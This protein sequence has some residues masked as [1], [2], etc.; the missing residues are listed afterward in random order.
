MIKNG[1]YWVKHFE[2]SEWTPAQYINGMWF[3]IGFHESFND[4]ELFEI[5]CEVCYENLKDC[6]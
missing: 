3:L 6:C 1:F 2:N 4:I 5:S